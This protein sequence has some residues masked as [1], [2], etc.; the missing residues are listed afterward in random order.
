MAEA[1]VSLAA[2]QRY[3]GAGTVEFVVDAERGDFYFLEMNTRIQ[4]EHPVTEMLTGLDLVGLQIRLAAGD[5]LA[6]V[7]QAEIRARGHA[8]EARIY[9]ENPSK[10]FMPS[11]GPLKLFRTPPAAP[12]LRIDTGVREGDAISFHYDPMI[13]KMIA[14]GV[15]RRAAIERLLGALGAMQVEG[16]ATNIDFLR[17]LMANAAFRAGDSHTGF[18]PAHAGD[19][20]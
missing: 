15:D 12:E 19:L 20:L 4:V 2:E 18:I 5:P 9:A 8:I 17:R 6:E 1:A 10:N 16:V 13:A 3:A 14:H 11:P 7:A